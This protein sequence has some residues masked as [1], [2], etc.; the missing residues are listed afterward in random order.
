MGE[1][2]CKELKSQVGARGGEAGEI[3]IKYRKRRDHGVPIITYK[4]NRFVSIAYY[5]FSV[6]TR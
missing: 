4:D 2:S 1:R 6:L 3:A 5:I